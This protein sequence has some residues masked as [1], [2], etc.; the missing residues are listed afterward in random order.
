M[1]SQEGTKRQIYLRAQE[2]RQQGLLY[3][4]KDKALEN[5]FFGSIDRFVE[6]AFA[7]QNCSSVLDVGSGHGMFLALLHCLGHECCGLDFFDKTEHP[8]MVYSMHGIKLSRCNIEISPFPYPEHTFDAVTCCQVLEHFTHSHLPAVLEMMRVLKP[9]G[10]LE[11]DVPNV[12]CF[13]NRSRILR[14]K[15]ITYDYQEH[16][17]LAKPVLDQGHSFF[18]LR[19]NREFTKKELEL[20]LKTAGFCNIDVQF[21]KSRRYRTGITRLI[22]AATS[23]RDLIPSW[24]KSLIAFSNKPA[25]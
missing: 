11:V 22:G 12:A 10:I 24:R 13:R 15:N 9:G 3:D 7:L 8:S 23:V 20:L 19:H 4:L 5:V 1:N 25:N 17:L 16:Y 2:F 14:G 18:F 21:L 6:I